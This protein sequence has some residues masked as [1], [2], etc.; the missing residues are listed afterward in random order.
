AFFARELKQHPR[1]RRP[2]ANTATRRRS[3]LFER[4]QKP[5]D[6]PMFQE[7]RGFWVAIPEKCDRVVDGA[8]WLWKLMLRAA[9][10]LN[11]LEQVLPNDR[12]RSVLVAHRSPDS[13]DKLENLLGVLL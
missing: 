8:I 10:Q 11:R 3:R 5:L 4:S 12:Q 9:R 2:K 6:T 13:L 7:A 1:E